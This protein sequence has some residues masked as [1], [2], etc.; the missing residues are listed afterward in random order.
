ML[1][2]LLVFARVL[3]DK[4]KEWKTVAFHWLRVFVLSQHHFWHGVSGRG[5]VTL[6]VAGHMPLPCDWEHLELFN[7]SS[8]TSDCATF[9]QLQQQLVQSGEIGV[10]KRILPG[11]IGELL[12][13]QPGRIGELLKIQP[14]EIGELRTTQPGWIGKLH[15]LCQIRLGSISG[16]LDLQWPL[17]KPFRELVDSS[18]QI[19]V[20]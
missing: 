19:L 16:H 8:C 9:V 11:G 2:Y 5:Q 12:K 7:N 3:T 13:I 18:R 17:Q 15:I 6:K 1:E 20:C 14:G 4:H 10:L